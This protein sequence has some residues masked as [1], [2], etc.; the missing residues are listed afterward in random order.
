MQNILMAWTWAVVARKKT[1]S[2]AL[3]VVTLTGERAHG[4]KAKPNLC[5]L[6]GHS[7]DAHDKQYGCAED[8]CDCET[9]NAGIHRAA[10][11]RPVE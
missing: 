4:I 3:D 9:P 6:C 11:G 8:G 2:R 10:E 7:I 5:R 1:M